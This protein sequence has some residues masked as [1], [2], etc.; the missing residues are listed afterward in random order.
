[1]PELPEVE[2]VRRGLDQYLVGRRVDAA[3]VT[4]ARTV[5]AS[6]AAAVETAA[7]GRVIT[8]TGRHGKWMWLSLDDDL[9]RLYIHLRM[10][11]QLLWGPSSTARRPHTHAVFT[12][13]DDELRFVDPRTFGEIVPGP[14][15]APIA[16]VA[17]QGPDALTLDTLGWRAVLAGR[18]TVLKTLITDQQ[19]IAG[20]GNIYADEICHRAGLRP[21]RAADTLPG[22]AAERL[23]EATRGILSSSI[24]AG[25]SSLFDEQYVD[26]AGRPGRYQHEHR[27]HA[28]VGEPCGSCGT[29]VQRQTLAGRG[30]YWCSRCQK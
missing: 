29:P 17:K 28:R 30:T 25:G 16:S 12:L 9:V 15:G 1:M 2:T 19:R 23:G 18:R 24:A 22:T 6:S 11:G 3:K 26:L 20:I 7:I 27:V 13:G 4:G 21:A 14:G 10:S 5:R 8:G